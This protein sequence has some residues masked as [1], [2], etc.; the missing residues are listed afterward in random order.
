MLK[1]TDRDRFIRSGSV[2][3]LTFAL[4]RYESVLHCIDDYMTIGLCTAHEN[5]YKHLS[6]FAIH[7][8]SLMNLNSYLQCRE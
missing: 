2:R 5:E 3:T 8:D 4:S 1:A 7:E 6:V